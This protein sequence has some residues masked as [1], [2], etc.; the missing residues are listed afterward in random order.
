MH[1]IASQ[2]RYAVIISIIV[3]ELYS[4]RFLAFAFHSSSFRL[5][6]FPP[7]SLS[8]IDV[9]LR[10]TINDDSA[11]DVISKMGSACGYSINLADSREKILNIKLYRFGGPNVEEH[12]KLNPDLLSQQDALRS[13]TPTFDDRGVQKVFYGN[14][15]T[16]ESVQFYAFADDAS[17]FVFTAEHVYGNAEAVLLQ[18]HEVLGSIEAVKEYESKEYGSTEYERN[19]DQEKQIL[20]ELKNLSVQTYARRRG[21]GKALTEAVQDYALHQ[22]SIL[23]QQENLKFTAIVHLIVESDNKGA[24]RLYKESGFILDDPKVK[25]QLCKMTW[26]TEGNTAE[27]CRTES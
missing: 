8:N 26:S 12:M 10:S 24:T 19:V 21:I 27:Y 5:N 17:S 20:I 4:N 18:S 15:G 6:T 16:G 9:T 7:G 1:R 11:D 13:L 2:S 3:L 22:V 14:G 25:G 23:E